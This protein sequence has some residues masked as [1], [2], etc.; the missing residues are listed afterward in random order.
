MKNLKLW[1]IL[2]LV[3]AGL[4]FF[5]MSD[6]ETQNLELNAAT[7][8]T[9]LV[10]MKGPCGGTGATHVAHITD[11]FESEWRNFVWWN[12]KCWACH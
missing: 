2:L 5:N 12:G 10:A 7:V 11:Q 8:S 1:S 9:D 3:A 4:V 6:S